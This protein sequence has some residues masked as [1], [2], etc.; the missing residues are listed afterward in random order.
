MS[1]GCPDGDAEYAGGCTSLETISDVWTK[2]TH[3][4][5]FSVLVVG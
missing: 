5:T 4:E 1:L 2:D 3:L